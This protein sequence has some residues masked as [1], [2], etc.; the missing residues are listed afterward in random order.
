MARPDETPK[1]HKAETTHVSAAKAIFPTQRP[2]LTP[3]ISTR[4]IRHLS[5]ESKNQLRSS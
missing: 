2:T 3:K 1:T 5:M 4:E